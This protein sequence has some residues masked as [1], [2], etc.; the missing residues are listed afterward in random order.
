L[1]PFGLLIRASSFLYRE[2]ATSN[3]SAGGAEQLRPPISLNTCLHAFIDGYFHL[4]EAPFVP[5]IGD[6]ILGLR[7]LMLRDSWAGAF[8]KFPTA[9]SRP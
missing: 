1:L 2:T 3:L 9:I 8:E 7:P 6:V 4:T 5:A